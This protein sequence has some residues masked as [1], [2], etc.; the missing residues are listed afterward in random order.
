MIGENLRIDA[1][2][3]YKDVKDL[4][5]TV[6]ASSKLTGSS[7]GKATAFSNGDYGSVKGFDFTLDKMA[8]GSK[9]SGSLSYSYMIAMGKGA[10]AT[11]AYYT[12]LTSTSDT[13]AP[14][15][16]YRLDFDQR[17]TVTAVI[18][19]RVPA[20]WKGSLFGISI[21]GNW[22]FNFVGYYGSGLPYTKTDS[23]GNRLGERNEGQLPASYSV[24]CRFNKNFKMGP[25]S[26]SMLTWFVEVDN[27]FNRRNILNVYSHTGV[28]D[29]DNTRAT[30]GLGTSQNQVDQLD[31]L[32]D[33]DPQ[34]YS[35]PR[36]VR[37][38]FEF[39]F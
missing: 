5:T 33:H 3:Y 29:N 17:H 23:L 11:D 39:S 4:V 7:S 36:T 22:G 37:T 31:Q 24:D 2:A 28:P 6:H 15:K 21:P 32:Y 26:K 12:Y 38:G 13:L 18:D 9:L 14:I 10:N 1:T 8:S 20:D 30:A 25:S 35:S 19:Y 16:E 34:N 27:L